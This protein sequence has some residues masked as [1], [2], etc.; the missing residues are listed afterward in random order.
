MPEIIDNVAKKCMPNERYIYTDV[1]NDIDL[2]KYYD[3]ILMSAFIDVMQHPLEVLKKVLN[4]AYDYVI[5]HRQEI[6]KDKKTNC[7]KNHSHGGF[8]Y[9]SIINRKDFETAIKK[10]D[11]IKKVDCKIDIWESGGTSFI[12]K[13]KK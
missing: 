7:V 1:Y 12:L 8:T 4:L 2:I 5:I 10:F 9:N 3:V 6:S 11:I 13:R